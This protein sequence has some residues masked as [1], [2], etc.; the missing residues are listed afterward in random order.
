MDSSFEVPV[1][2]FDGKITYGM[3]RKANK[4]IYKGHVEELASSVSRLA[5][6]ERLAQDTFLKMKSDGKWFM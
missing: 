4:T 3:H 5:D 2:E 6:M 1:N